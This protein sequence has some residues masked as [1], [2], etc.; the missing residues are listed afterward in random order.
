MKEVFREIDGFEGYYVSNKGTIKFLRRLK[1]GRFSERIL[2][3]DP[4]K[5]SIRLR[6]TGG[7]YRSVKVAILVAEAF[8]PGTGN[9][10]KR[11]HHKDGNEM[12][13]V[14]SNLEW[15]GINRDDVRDIRKMLQ[16]GYSMGEVARKYDINRTHVRRIRENAV[17]RDIF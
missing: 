5:A 1:S 9:G 10:R 13:N 16:E 17:W 14:Y 3:M 2:T 15:E 11:V 4:D 6:R 8:L 7:G 12:N